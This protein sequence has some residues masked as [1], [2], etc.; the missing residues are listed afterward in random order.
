MNRRSFFGFLAVSPLVVKA[1]SIP[2]PAPSF[3]DLAIELAPLPPMLKARRW[4]ATVGVPRTIVVR[5]DP[6][7]LSRLAQSADPLSPYPY[8]FS[9]NAKSAPIALTKIT[10]MITASNVGT[11]DFL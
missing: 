7:A 1:A 2:A 6:R 4:K 9:S 3:A 11:G 5:N 10:N 8:S